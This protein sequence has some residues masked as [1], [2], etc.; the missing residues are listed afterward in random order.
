MSGIAHQTL[1]ACAVLLSTACGG[2]ASDE[3]VTGEPETPP[4]VSTG[5]GIWRI[6][7]RPT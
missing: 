6:A 3:D 4:A 1:A 7:A 5:P 2:V